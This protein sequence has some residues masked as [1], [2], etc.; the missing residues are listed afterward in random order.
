MGNV[1]TEKKIWQFCVAG[2]AIGMLILFYGIYV[3]MNAETQTKWPVAQGKI[4]FVAGRK[5]TKLRQKK[6]KWTTPY[7]NVVLWITATLRLDK[8]IE[9]AS[10]A[11]KVRYLA[12]T[13]VERWQRSTMTQTIQAVQF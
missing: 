7:F 13:V 4:T 6:R 5:I 12:N 1:M 3:W 11:F 9:D 10:A 8:A 2:I